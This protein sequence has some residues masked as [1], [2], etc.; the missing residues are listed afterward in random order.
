MRRM[1]YL[2]TIRMKKILKTLKQKYSSIDAIKALNIA[3]EWAAE[4]SD[5]YNDVAVLRKLREKAVLQ[6]LKGNQIQKK[7]SDYFN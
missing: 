2:K 6:A 4:K 3:I 7:I 5:D 1:V